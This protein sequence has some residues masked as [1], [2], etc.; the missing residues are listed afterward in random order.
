M[1]NVLL[2]I[3]KNEVEVVVDANDLLELDDVG[4]VELAEWDQDKIPTESTIIRTAKVNKEVLDQAEV[5]RVRNQNK[6]CLE[7]GL[8]LEAV[9]LEC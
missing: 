3:F 9:E 4:V 7:S 2:H 5:E 8:Q 1:V 6:H